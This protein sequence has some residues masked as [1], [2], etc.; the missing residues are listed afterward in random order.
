[1][2]SSRAPNGSEWPGKQILHFIIL[3]NQLALS[4]IMILDIKPGIVFVD[5]VSQLNSSVSWTGMIWVPLG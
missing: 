3:Q 2:T 4:N 5:L 1:M